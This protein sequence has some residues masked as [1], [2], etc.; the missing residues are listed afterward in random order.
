[1][2]LTISLKTAAMI[3][4]A[5]NSKKRAILI[6]CIFKTRIILLPYILLF[7]FRKFLSLLFLVHKSV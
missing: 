6:I 5:S 2:I 3:S 7:K 1:M 4:L